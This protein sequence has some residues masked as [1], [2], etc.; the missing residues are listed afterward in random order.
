MKKTLIINGSPR[1]DGNTAA[2]IAELRKSLDGEVVELSA[3]RSN[4]APCT[5]CRGCWQDAKCVVH[6]DMSIIYDD[7]FD[8]VV[9]AAPVY[10]CTLP[11]Q[12]L[13]LM[14]RFQPQH[15]AT[16]FLKK[17]TVLKEKKAGLILTAGGKGN[18]DGAEHHIWV[19]FK[20]MNARGYDGHRVSSL[21]T[22]EVFAGNDAAALEQAKSL[23]SWLNEN[24]GVIPPEPPPAR[25]RFSCSNGR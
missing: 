13:S 1:A 2:L 18:E 20:M 14:S 22:D 6:D 23:A 17:P 25:R 7:D 21:N 4:I 10:Y 15:A 9:L 19:M 5:D 11:G 12:V 3:F 24:S 8:N 16:Y